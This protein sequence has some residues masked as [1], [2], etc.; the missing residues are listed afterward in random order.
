MPNLSKRSAIKEVISDKAKSKRGSFRRDEGAP[1]ELERVFDVVCDE[2]TR[3]VV[4]AGKQLP[5]E[6]T[7]PDLV[8]TV[9]GDEAIHI[10]GFLTDAYY[11]LML[12]GPLV[13]P[14]Y[15]EVS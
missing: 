9:I 15:F 2:Y 8:R 11:D 10:P 14:R 6:W 3:C 5:S 13:M 4:K 1:P 12:C 7:M